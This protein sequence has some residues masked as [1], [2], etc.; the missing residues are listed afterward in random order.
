MVRQNLRSMVGLE[1]I[2]RHLSS[3]RG[4]ELNGKRVR[5]VGCDEQPGRYRAH[6]QIEGV[7]EPMRLKLNNLSAAEDTR[8]DDFVAVPERARRRR[9]EAV[10]TSI[11]SLLETEY[12]DIDVRR[13]RTDIVG[14][15]EYTR[16]HATA[17]RAPP[18]LL[19]GASVTQ[20]EHSSWSQTIGHVKPC[21]YGDNTADL[22]AMPV[23]DGLSLLIKEWVGSGLCG[24]CQAVIF[25]EERHAGMQGT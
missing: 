24:R 1:F 10:V 15:I 4:A 8:Y 16:L 5:V 13:S 18:P 12:T 9:T 20:G 22:R 21:C 14:R 11:R 6:C 23:G 2:V 25:G 3:A 19:C 17:G 7:A